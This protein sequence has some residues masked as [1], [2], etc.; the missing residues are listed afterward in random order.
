MRFLNVRKSGV[1]LAYLLMI[2]LTISIAGPARPSRRNEV[3]RSLTQKYVN[4]QHLAREDPAEDVKKYDGGADVI[5]TTTEPSIPTTEDYLPVEQEVISGGQSLP[6]SLLDE[7]VPAS[8]AIESDPQDT[9][10]STPLEA[11]AVQD[12]KDPVIDSK[13]ETPLTAVAETLPESSSATPS[14]LPLNAPVR[15]PM[16]ASEPETTPLP[17]KQVEPVIHSSME[18]VNFSSNKLKKPAG[19]K[20][21]AIK[22]GT[23]VHYKLEQ[24]KRRPVVSYEAPLN[25]YLSEEQDQPIYLP[26]TFSALPL[27]VSLYSG[28]EDDFPRR[29]KKLDFPR[30]S[31]TDENFGLHV[32]WWKK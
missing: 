7:P 26:P 19:G 25:P 28:E 30:I 12:V 5:T 18:D 4:V 10:E 22:Y 29:P 20:K 9:T 15:V 24:P 8:L 31:N 13:T 23:Q 21:P 3:N 1:V 2:Q 11:E 14:D 27:A 32:D 6:A 16:I 17:V